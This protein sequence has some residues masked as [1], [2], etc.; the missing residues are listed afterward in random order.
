MFKLFQVHL[1]ED[2]VKQ[3]NATGHDSVPKQKARLQASV[4]GDP[5][6]AIAGGFFEH[7]S[8]I[9]A[10]SLEQAFHVANMG[11]EEKI[12]RLGPMFSMSVGDVV[13][14]PAGKQWVVASCGF[15]PVAEKIV[16]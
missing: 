3:V 12:E 16:C 4:F 7:V 11:P 2:E 15:D 14:D 1:T 8:N 9:E 5:S 13:E 10:S 6:E